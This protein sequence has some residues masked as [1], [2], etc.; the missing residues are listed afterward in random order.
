MIFTPHGAEWVLEN[1]PLM[2][3]ME[4]FMYNNSGMDGLYGVKER[5][6]YHNIYCSFDADANMTARR[7]GIRNDPHAWFRHYQGRDLLSKG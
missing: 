1:K 4:F 3:Q 2:P 6:L 7:E 5:I